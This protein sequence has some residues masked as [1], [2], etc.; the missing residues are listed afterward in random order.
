MLA[1]QLKFMK[2]GKEVRVEQNRAGAKMTLSTSRTRKYIWTLREVLQL[3]LQK[4]CKSVDLTTAQK[5]QG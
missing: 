3:S 4:G 2:W 5:G 1:S